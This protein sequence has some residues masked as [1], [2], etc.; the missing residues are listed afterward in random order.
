MSMVARVLVASD[1]RI[2]VME[3]MAELTMID[4]VRYGSTR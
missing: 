3:R 4:D 1:L 2:F